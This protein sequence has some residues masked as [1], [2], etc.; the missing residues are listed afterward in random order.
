MVFSFKKTNNSFTG[1][2][3]GALFTIVKLLHF[4]RQLDWTIVRGPMLTQD[5]PKGDIKVGYVGTVTGFKLTR[6][7]L[8]K[9]ILD[10]IENNHSLNQVFL[11]LIRLKNVKLS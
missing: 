3:I 9:F 6:A 2:K 4:S 7:D 1:A 10:I 8:A 11:K 5:E